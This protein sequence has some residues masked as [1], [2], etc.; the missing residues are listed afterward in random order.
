MSVCLSVEVSI[1]GFRTLT[2]RRTNRQDLSVVHV[3][4]RAATVVVDVASNLPSLQFVPEIS[5]LSRMLHHV[6]CFINY[7]FAFYGRTG[8]CIFYGRTGLCIFQMALPRVNTKVFFSPPFSN[9]L[10]RVNTR[11]FFFHAL[12]R[13]AAQG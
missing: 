11:V 9:G 10:P 5:K 3:R 13:R 12:F 7:G 2:D 1:L 8:L 6:L 4:F